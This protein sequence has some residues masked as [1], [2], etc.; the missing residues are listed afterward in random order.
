MSVWQLRDAL[1]MSRIVP[2]F[3]IQF[4]LRCA[5][6]TITGME[7]CP[8]TTR[9]TDPYITLLQDFSSSGIRGVF[10]L[11]NSSDRQ[12]SSDVTQE[13]ISVIQGAYNV[14]MHNSCIT[15]LLDKLI[16]A[17]MDVALE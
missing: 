7:I 13:L 10:R 14:S 9:Q 1:Q 2:V 8:D 17:T 5:V 4:D 11:F 15:T 12:S 16:A 3:V 6:D